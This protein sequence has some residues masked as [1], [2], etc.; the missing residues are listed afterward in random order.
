MK[1][2]IGGKGMLVD[3]YKEAETARGVAEFEKANVEQREAFKDAINNGWIDNKDSPYFREAV[4]KSHTK[5]LLNRTSV[6][7]YTA[8]EKWEGKNDPNSGSFDT[9]L[10]EQDEKIAINLEAI[11][12]HILKADFHEQHQALSLIHI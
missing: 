2:F 4:T 5:N 1:E 12:D 9:W 6:D 10:A 8:Y 3:Q 7:L 11:P